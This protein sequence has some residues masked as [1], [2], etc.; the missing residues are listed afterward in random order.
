M[1]SFDTIILNPILNVLLINY[2]LFSTIG[3]PF[4]LGFAIIGLTIVIRLILYPLMSAQLKAAKRMQEVSPHLSKLKEK[5]KNDAKLLQQETMKLYKEFGVNPAAGC[6][7]ILVQLPVIWGLYSV[8]IKVINLGSNTVAEVNRLAYSDFLKIDKTWDVYFF[9]LPLAQNP[10][11]LLSTMGPI[12]L[13]VPLLT[14]L[15]QF[16]QSKMMLPK[17]VLKEEKKIAEA[18]PTKKDDFATAFQ[19]QSLYIFPIMIGF[20][21]YTFPI[22]LSLYWNTFT[23]FGIIQQYKISGLGGLEDLTRQIWKRN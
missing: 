1:I 14:G 17:K 13:L 12:I 6:L 11:Q 22:G 21:S 23:I 15:F 9:A 7:P 16:I 5:Y 8:L 20:L 18:T 2:K 19:S 4:A 10:G 3:V